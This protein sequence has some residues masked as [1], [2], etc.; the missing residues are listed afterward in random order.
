MGLTRLGSAWHSPIDRVLAGIGGEGEPPELPATDGLAELLDLV[1]TW[2]ER[3][4]LTA[5]RTPEELVDLFVADAALLARHARSGASWVDVGSGGGAPGLPLGIL[6]RDLSIT[7]VEPR[8]KRVAFLRSAIGSLKL[9]RVRAERKRAEDL[10]AG[11]FDTAV[12]RA[13]FS[14]Q[15]WLELAGRLIRD[16]LWILVAK[17][18]APALAG[19]RVADDLRY[20]W[21][22]TGAERRA[23]RIVRE[24]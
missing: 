5:A 15:K 11:S 22:L 17:A 19:F 1:V 14:P 21:P 24:S 16:D 10:E 20:R 7:L 4:D 13:T 6:R 8:I 3:I 23:L 2:N 18:E 12:S 9:E